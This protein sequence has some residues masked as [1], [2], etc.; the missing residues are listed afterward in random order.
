M[1]F[2]PQNLRAEKH[3]IEYPGG[4]GIGQGKHIVLISGDE[5]YRSEEALPLLARILSSNY[6]FNCTVLFAIDPA[7]GIVNPNVTNNIPGLSN[8]EKADLMVI[9]TRF[10]ALPDNQMNQIEQYLLKGKPVLGIRTATHAFNFENPGQYSHYSNGYEGEK[11]DWADGFGRLVLGEKWI[12]HHGRHKHESTR[13]IVSPDAMQHPIARGIRNG[14]IWG[15]TDVYGVRL[16]LPGDSKPVI[17]GE[18]IQRSGEYAESDIFFGMKPGDST[19]VDSK[20]DPMMPIAWTKSYRIPGGKIGRAFTSTIGAST[21]L[22][23]AGTR[24]LLINAVFW[25]LGIEDQIPDDG[26]NVDFAGSYNPTAY[27]FRE[28]EYWQKQKMKPQDLQ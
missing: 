6:G 24:R 2:V 1:I 3:W 25:C 22:I 19:P 21:D 26:S 18:V 11:A 7:T 12:S 15:P 9:F 10:R 13:G 27:G 14:D 5:E 23:S 8:L 20:N 4:S 28:N 17:L 16:P